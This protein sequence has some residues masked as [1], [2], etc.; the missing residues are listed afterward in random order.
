MLGVLVAAVYGWRLL[1]GWGGPSPAALAQRALTAGSTAERQQAAVDLASAGQPAIEH[2]RRVLGASD[3]ADVR[4]ACVQGLGDLR[5]YESAELLIDAL[6]DEN[7]LVRALA[8]Q[9]LGRLLRR[10]LRFPADGPTAG[11]A[12]AQAAVRDTLPATP[13][14]RPLGA[15]PGGQGLGLLLRPQYASSCSRPRK[16]PRR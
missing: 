6:G 2:L 10:D 5:D 4:A 15:S 7:A 11:R 14:R 9:A 1:Q 8:A 16:R 3:D 13:R 12:K